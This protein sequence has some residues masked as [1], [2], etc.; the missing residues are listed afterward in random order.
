MDSPKLRQSSKMENVASTVVATSN[1]PIN[2]VRPEPT[3]TSDSDSALQFITCHHFV[4]SFCQ[5]YSPAHWH[6]HIEIIHCLTGE[7]FFHTSA[8]KS[9]RFN[10]PALVIVPSN[11]IHRTSFPPHCRI[12]RIQFD[13]EVIRLSL[14]D[15]ALEHS[16]TLL[17]G[18]AG[19]GSLVI[20]EHDFG[21]EYLS[22]LLSH[23]EELVSPLPLSELR[24]NALTQYY[25][26]LT[27][28]S[29]SSDTDSDKEEEEEQE[30]LQPK[31]LKSAE[32]LRE[33]QAER[34]AQALANGHDGQKMTPA[35]AQAQAE[36]QAKAL[37]QVAS[38]VRQH[39]VEA[40]AQAVAANARADNAEMAAQAA[41]HMA[42]KAAAVAASAAAA[43]AAE[44][45]E[46]EG[47]ASAEAEARVVGSSNDAIAYTRE[48]LSH[49]EKMRYHSLGLRLQVKAS[50]LQLLGAL[51][52]HYYL[53]SGKKLKGPRGSRANDDT[54]KELLNFIHQNY[55]RALTISQMAERLQVTNQYFCRLFKQ[56]TDMSFIDYINALRIQKAAIELAT[57]KNS[58]RDISSRYGF[59]A[60]GYFFKQFRAHYHTTP[61][62][63]RKS[64]TDHRGEPIAQLDAENGMVPLSSLLQLELKDQR[65]H[66]SR[67]SQGRTALTSAAE[68]DEAESDELQKLRAQGQFSNLMSS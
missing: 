45:S 11:L 46:P 50:L 59:E 30:E 31:E 60:I 20:S 49:S 27:T 58:I 48:G 16:L 56:T 12:T 54:I 34:E 38:M 24:V 67:A 39:Q 23:L 7:G 64:F 28:Q 42:A 37:A 2:Y 44:A 13:P 68:A 26:E 14:S 21:Y 22:A 32:I 29:D 25:K 52:E 55:T 6:P 41:E 5:S 47:A 18:A 62:K 57:S 43:A 19:S 61:V 1:A 33:E 66:E 8:G 17:S 15:P 65:T 40:A 63:Y 9:V 4:G 36:A 53:V 10:A 35:E 3:V 51:F